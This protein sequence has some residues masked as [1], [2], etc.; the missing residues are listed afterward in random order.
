MSLLGK[1]ESDTPKE[2]RLETIGKACIPNFRGDENFEYKDRRPYPLC[3][4]RSTLEEGNNE[5]D[6]THKKAVIG[7]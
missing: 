5:C 4:K 6:K 2:L 7:K 1:Q 3:A